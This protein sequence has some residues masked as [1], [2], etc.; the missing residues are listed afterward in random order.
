MG[1]VVDHLS[2]LGVLHTDLHELLEGGVIAVVPVLKLIEVG[3]NWAGN[4]LD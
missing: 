4:S 2:A 1:T 3:L